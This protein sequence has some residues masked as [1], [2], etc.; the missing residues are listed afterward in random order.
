MPYKLAPAGLEP[1]IFE[2]KPERQQHGHFRDFKEFLRDGEHECEVPFHRYEN[3][4]YIG[5]ANRRLRL[6]DYTEVFRKFLQKVGIVEKGTL[7]KLE[8][9]T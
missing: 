2:L 9:D 5:S 8:F 6:R 3:R 1:S 4:F 7:I